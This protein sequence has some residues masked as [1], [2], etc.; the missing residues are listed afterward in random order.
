MCKHPK[1]SGHVCRSLHAEQSALR[2]AQPGDK[3]FVIR[4]QKNGN[5]AI[6][7]PCNECTKLIKS[8]KLKKVWYTD[9]EGKWQI[10]K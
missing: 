6:S 7:K 1:P 4:F 8:L 5:I 9:R 2:R 3:L 10:L